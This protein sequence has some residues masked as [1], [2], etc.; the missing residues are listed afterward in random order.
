MGIPHG[1]GLDDSPVDSV[2]H[3]TA[4]LVQFCRWLKKEGKR[5]IV[6]HPVKRKGEKQQ[7]KSGIIGRDP[8]RDGEG[9]E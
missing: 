6:N 2:N 4:R 3:S 7:E 1:P 8:G 9:R 5:V